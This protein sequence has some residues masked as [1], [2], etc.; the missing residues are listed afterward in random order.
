MLLLRKRRQL[1]K[2]CF[3]YSNSH[4]CSAE[5]VRAEQHF[6]TNMFVNLDSNPSSNLSYQKPRKLEPFCAVKNYN[7][8]CLGVRFLLCLQDNF[9]GTLKS[10]S[11]NRLPRNE[12]TDIHLENG[13]KRSHTSNWIIK[14]IHHNRADISTMQ[15]VILRI[16][17]V[18]S[19][20]NKIG[21]SFR[22]SRTV[23][24]FRRKFHLKMLLTNLQRF[25]WVS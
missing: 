25:W 24:R 7:H 9:N 12:L 8:A 22:F 23:L 16:R 20:Q 4:L 15:N 21:L 18:Q 17:N 5:L 2:V 13:A 19:V 6:M 3:D 10:A 11:N 1:R 14:L